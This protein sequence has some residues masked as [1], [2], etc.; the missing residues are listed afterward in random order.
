[1]SDSYW[2]YTRSFM[3]LEQAKNWINKGDWF[4]EDAIVVRMTS[5]DRLGYRSTSDLLQEDV[6][7][8]LKENHGGGDLRD[9]DRDRMPE[10]DGSR[11]VQ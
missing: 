11:V 4:G 3:S 10:V 9:S 1:L 6:A 5:G 2:V 8:R 7:Y